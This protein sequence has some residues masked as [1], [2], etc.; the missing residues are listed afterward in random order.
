MQENSLF[1]MLKTLRE[2]EEVI[3]YNNLLE[4]PQQH[5]QEALEYLADE[6]NR[7]KIDYPYPAPPFDK[8]AAQWGMYVTYFATQLILYREHKSKDLDI[9]F[10]QFQNKITAGSVLSADICLRFIPQIIYQLNLIDIED[11][12]KKKLENI[13]HI[14]HYSGL[15]YTSLD[16]ENLDFSVITSDPCL[17][18]LY[19]DRVIR[20]KN[21]SVA[22]HPAIIHHIKS[23]LGLYHQDFWKDLKL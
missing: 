10:T 5:I 4:I 20:F 3:L 14:W 12:L 9:L 19:V 23:S 7:E 2:K 18:Q 16:S 17:L 15:E 11:P 13:L 6:Y 22:C 1:L 8:Y 21:K